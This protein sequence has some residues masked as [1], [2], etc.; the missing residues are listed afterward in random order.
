MTVIHIK[1][2]GSHLQRR[3]YKLTDGQVA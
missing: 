2:K 3:W 1:M